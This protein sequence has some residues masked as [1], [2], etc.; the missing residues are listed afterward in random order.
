MKLIKYLYTSHKH[1]PK[2]VKF[3]TISSFFKK[4]DCKQGT[5]KRKT[6]QTRDSWWKYGFQLLYW[7][8]LKYS[9]PESSG[10]GQTSNGPPIKHFKVCVSFLA[11]HTEWRLNMKQK[12][13]F[14]WKSGWKTP[15]PFY[16]P[17]RQDC[18]TALGES[19]AYIYIFYSLHQ[20]VCVLLVQQVF[21]KF[22]TLSPFYCI[23][24][25][26]QWALSPGTPVKYILKSVSVPPL[27]C[28]PLCVS[29]APTPL[30]QTGSNR[31]QREIFHFH[32]NNMYLYL[33]DHMLW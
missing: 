15:P 20:P 13:Q 4:K 27:H 12:V 6:W 17:L 21:N 28:W 9:L 11:R 1:W 24:L 31:E 30:M 2:P 8:P 19:L 3:Y 25:Y 33:F 23:I 18:K 26:E 16:F 7:Q 22:I 32:A 10:L 5:G 14:G 29:S